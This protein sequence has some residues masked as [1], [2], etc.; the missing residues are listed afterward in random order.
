LDA[1]LESHGDKTLVISENLFSLAS[2][3]RLLPKPFLRILL[4][5]Y[6]QRMDRVLDED[7][8]WMYELMMME[9]TPLENSCAPVVPET[10][11]LLGDFFKEE[12]SV[13][14]DVHF[15]Y[16]LSETF[17]GKGRLPLKKRR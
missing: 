15:E 7:T 3:W 14:A 2:Y 6:R 16:R 1:K 12:A 13:S 9:S 4:W 10:Y 5:L 11:D 8:E 17:D